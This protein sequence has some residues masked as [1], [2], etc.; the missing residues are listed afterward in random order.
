MPDDARSSPSDDPI[1]A[2]LLEDPG[3]F[4]LPHGYRV[5]DELHGEAPRGLAVELKQG[6]HA[7]RQRRTVSLLLIAATICTSLGVL[8]IVREWGLFV[9]PLQYI[10]WIGVGLGFLGIAAYLSNLVRLGPYRYVVEGIP[11]PVRI[12]TLELRPTSIVNAQPATYRFFASVDFPDPVTGT[13]RSVETSSNDFSAGAKDGLTTSYRVGDYATA[14]YL[15]EDFEQ[16]LRLYGF[17]D[18][19]PAIGLLRRDG[20][21]SGS[22]FKLAL[23]MLAIVGFFGILAWNIYALGKFQPVRISARELV[24]PIVLGAIGLGGGLLGF[25]VLEQR[26]ARIRRSQRNAEATAQGE[27]FEPPVAKSGWFGSHGVGMG[28]IIIAGSLLLGGLTAVCWAFTANALLDRSPAAYRPIQV[29]ETVSVTHNMIFREYKV[30]YHFLKGDQAKQ[31]HLSNPG[32]MAGLGGQVAFAEVHSGLFG[33][34]W[35]KSLVSPRD[36]LRQ[37][38]KAK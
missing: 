14:V 34:P 27:A 5:E 19:N 32:E 9:L 3:P 7:V 33:W 37:K 16:T 8:P 4:E 11:L 1:P 25:L 22:V 31:S 35:V 29:D 15:A 28:L 23:L 20:S 21:D 18:L 38:A 10:T 26:N 30:E 6:R 17:L 2:I 24:V 13:L 36:F 12:R